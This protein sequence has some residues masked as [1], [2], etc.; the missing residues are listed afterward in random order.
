MQSHAVTPLSQA[1]QGAPSQTR[2][3]RIAEVQ[4]RTG[5]SRSQIYRLIAAGQFPKPIRISEATSA[6][7][8]NEVQTWIE[9]RIAA[10]RVAQ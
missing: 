2:L 1:A 10:N 7:V 8:E 4:H 6:W 5:F 9:G 3:I